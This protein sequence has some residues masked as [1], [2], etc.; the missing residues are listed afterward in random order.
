MDNS[1][2]IDASVS[3]ASP[4]EG[5]TL[6][7]EDMAAEALVSFLKLKKKVIK[8]KLDKNKKEWEQ[9]ASGLEDLTKR[10][11]TISVTRGSLEKK[12]KEIINK[13][14]QE[15][16]DS[17]RR[18]ITKIKN[19]EIDGQKAVT[20][21]S[22]DKKKRI[23]ITTM[24]I[25]LPKSL[26]SDWRKDKDAGRFQ[27]MIDL[28]A[29]DIHAG[30]RA[31]NLDR[32]HG[33]YDHPNIS[34]SRFCYGSELEA[35]LDQEYREQ[36]LYEIVV[37][38]ID[39]LRSPHDGA[40]YTKWGMFCSKAKAREPNYSFERYEQEQKVKESD[41]VSAT[42]DHRSIL[43][44][45][46]RSVQA[47]EQM[48]YS[49]ATYVSP[50]NSYI[51]SWSRTIARINEVRNDMDTFEFL[52][53]TGMLPFA[54][55]Y[56]VRLIQQIG[57]GRPIQRIELNDEGGDY[58]L[59]CSFDMNGRTEISRIPCNRRDFDGDRPRVNSEV[60]GEMMIEEMPM[61]GGG[62]SGGLHGGGGGNTA[63]SHVRDVLEP[64]RLDANGL[65]YSPNTG[66]WALDRPEASEVQEETQMEASA[67][68][69]ENSVLTERN[70]E[71]LTELIQSQNNENTDPS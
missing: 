4:R 12:Y 43:D 51:A 24:P 68:P 15:V 35:D 26:R 14:K 69:A 54:V 41:G 16:L 58:K 25:K 19:Y 38:V 30:I 3:P 11:K 2:R 8:E 9:V 42:F 32:Y 49:T 45:M 47:T 39:L 61:G 67:I 22:V 64:S 65:R 36:D 63:G 62:A 55:S 28:K 52:R 10:Q 57:E 53:G 27:I 17:F 44:A 50:L 37:D 21:F 46:Q 71:R 56:Y 6:S 31:V 18:V 7:V 33:S 40:G 60:A 23:F 29:G 59:F 20:A 1:T 5:T 34:N 66:E 48:V 70:L 13:N